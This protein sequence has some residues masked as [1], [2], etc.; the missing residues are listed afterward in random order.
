MR[1]RAFLLAGFVLL[2]NGI[3][4]ARAEEGKAQPSEPSQAE[5]QF[6]VECRIISD[7]PKGLSFAP[8]KATVGEGQRAIL[9][10][11][12]ARSIVITEQPADGVQTPITRAVVEGTTIELMVTAHGPDKVILDLA[13][14]MTGAKD[15]PAANGRS[16]RVAFE[17]GRVIECVTLGR[18]TAAPLRGWTFE[19]LVTEAKPTAVAAA[20]PAPAVSSPASADSAASETA[21]PEASPKSLLRLLGRLTRQRNAD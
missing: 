20:S 3:Q 17:K 14:E 5:R 15:V 7:D 10:D 9:A 16:V 6:T 19:F 2:L 8:P 13:I 21:A 11:T 18:K 1:T 12:S 4:L